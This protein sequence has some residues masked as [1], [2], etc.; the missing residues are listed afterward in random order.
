MM[1]ASGAVPKFLYKFRSFNEY[2]LRSLDLTTVYYANPSAFNDPIDSKPEFV[3][4]LDV[5]NLE[6]LFRV[7]APQKADSAI[8]YH[9]YMSGQEGDYRIDKG[10]RDQYAGSIANDL[11]NTLLS[12]MG[13]CG[14]L[15]LT[16]RWNSPLMWSHYADE[17]RGIC[18][19]YA[20]DEGSFPNITPVN[21]RGC[22]SIYLSDVFAW[23]VL[24][25]ALAERKVRETMYFSKANDWRYEREWRSVNIT[26]GNQPS[27]AKTSAILFGHRCDFSVM[28]TIVRLFKEAK[29]PVKFYDVGF[30]KNSF[31][32]KRWKASVDELLSYQVGYLPGD[33]FSGVGNLRPPK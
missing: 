32:M 13:S 23:R 4:D 21:Y 5:A 14:V 28:R 24:N 2:T 19:E 20:M 29:Y 18:I 9:Q 8:Q 1:S 12:E 7:V 22:R 10:A 26:S 25:N 3:V 31:R 27:P 30:D 11:Q 17:H 6:K 16:A 15:S 33:E